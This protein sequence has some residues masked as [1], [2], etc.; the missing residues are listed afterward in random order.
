MY[1]RLA[2]ILLAILFSADV[3]GSAPRVLMDCPGCSDA[4]IRDLVGMTGDGIRLVVDFQRRFIR[5]YLVSGTPLIPRNQDGNIVRIADVQEVPVSPVYQQLYEALQQYYDLDPGLFSNFSITV[6][7]DRIGVDPN[8]GNSFQPF[9]IGFYGPSMF[10]HNNFVQRIRDIISSESW[11]RQALS[12]RLADAMFGIVH[13]ITGLGLQVLIGASINWNPTGGI[14]TINLCDSAGYCVRVQVTK[15]GEV[16][17]DGAFDGVGNRIPSLFGNGAAL[18]YPPGT[19]S[20]GERTGNELSNR[21]I[22]V[23]S[24]GGNGG[25]LYISCTY[26]NG[27]MV[28]CTIEARQN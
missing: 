15:S 14:W 13:R 25:W 6:P 16:I 26:I 20:H 21:G 18:G 17:F 2:A 11:T 4:Q 28:S 24:S 7:I 27:V 3:R 9:D 22:P 10:H 1:A 23:S 5:E 12:P 8:T 19:T